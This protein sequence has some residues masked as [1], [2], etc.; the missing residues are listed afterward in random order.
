MAV[1]LTTLQLSYAERRQL[2]LLI[3]AI[4]V[5]S[6]FVGLTQVA[7]G[8]SSPLRFFSITNP[9]E[10]VGFFANRNHFAALLYAVLVFAAAWAIDAGFKIQTWND[11]RT[12]SSPRTA[13]L[14]AIFLVF[15]V[16]IA[17][18]AMARSRAGL[19]LTMVALLAAFALAF[20]DPRKRAGA[21]ANKFLSVAIVV[22]ILLSLQFALYRILDRFGTDPLEQA[23]TTFGHVTFA[24][25]SAFMPF[26][27]GS[28][29]FV[30]VYQL[31]ERP[32]DLIA[33]T[34]VNHAHDDLLEIW[35]ET[36]IVGPAM[37]CVFLVWWVLTAMKLW[38]KPA[39]SVHAFDCTLARAATIVIGLLLAHS[40]VDYPMRTGAIMAVFAFSCACL[41][42][43][44]RAADQK[45]RIAPALPRE[46]RQRSGVP[47]RAV[48]MP[49]SDPSFAPV[50]RDETK[51]RPVP[52]FGGRWGEDVEWPDEWQ[53]PQAKG[54]FRSAGANSDPS[55]PNSAQPNG[56]PEPEV[57]D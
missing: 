24:A 3:I 18:E 17:G 23:R 38:R 53:N 29:T 28:G 39:P 12:L 34:Y 25:A 27:S 37:I 9:T 49:P 47:A 36:G 48:S 14:T 56:R 55:D 5:V 6:V 44:V 45:P 20:T 7:Q 19:A 8:Q 50:R 26:G 52:Q 33:D 22:A 43:P 4:G 11:I 30:P 54:D 13:A 35:L 16:V 51:T 10:A 40:L 42:E 21:K 57:K 41:I 1:F 31:F 46:A 2:T 32:T 15:I